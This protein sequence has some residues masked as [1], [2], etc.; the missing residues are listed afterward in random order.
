MTAVQTVCL[1]EP[2]TQSGLFSNDDSGLNRLVN[3]DL[4]LFMDLKLVCLSIKVSQSNVFIFKLRKVG[5]EVVKTCNHPLNCLC[6]SQTGSAPVVR[7]SFLGTECQETRCL[8]LVTVVLFIT[9]LVF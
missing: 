1:R 2:Q 9:R 5:L 3:M 8:K 4:K 7:C 6:V